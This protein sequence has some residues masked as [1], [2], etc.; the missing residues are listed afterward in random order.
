MESRLAHN[1]PAMSGGA[2]GGALPEALRQ[3][4]SDSMAQ[5][6][7]LPALVLLAGLVAALLFAKPTHLEQ[8]TAVP[9]SDDLEGLRG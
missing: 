4:F 7:I 6:L 3:G 8:P 5:S 9:G 1:L 2:S